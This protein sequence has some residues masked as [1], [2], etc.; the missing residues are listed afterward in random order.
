MLI[1]S[2]LT[3]VEA[4][5]HYIGYAQA[6]YCSRSHTW[7]ITWEHVLCLPPSKPVFFLWETETTLMHD[8]NAGIPRTHSSRIGILLIKMIFKR[9]RHCFWTQLR[10]FLLSLELRT[11]RTT[12]LI[13]ESKCMRMNAV[14]E[15]WSQGASITKLYISVKQN[16]L[17]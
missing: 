7:K 9:Y 11:V 5:I 1:H 3:E 8:I 2:H 10:T 4:Y 15:P 13:G 17:E 16:I 6:S 14:D 12:K